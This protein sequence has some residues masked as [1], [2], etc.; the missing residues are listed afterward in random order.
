[1]A[2]AQWPATAIPD[3][4]VDARTS[5]GSSDNV[6]LGIYGG[7]QWG[8]LGFRTGVFYTSH[9]ISTKRHVVFPAFNETL[10]ADYDARTT[11]AFAGTGLPDGF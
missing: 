10:S 5:S 4:D 8:A 3:F 2:L 7:T 11:Q 6:H 9:D 1:M